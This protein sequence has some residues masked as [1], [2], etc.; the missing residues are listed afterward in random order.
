MKKISRKYFK[1]LSFVMVLVLSVGFFGK[2]SEA[3]AATEPYLSGTMI[4]DSYQMGETFSLS[5]KVKGDGDYIEKIHIHYYNE[6]NSNDCG[7]LGTVYPD[8]KSYSL[9]KLG[10]FTV[11][12]DCFKKVNATYVVKAWAKNEG[13]ASVLLDSVRV[14]ITE[15]SEPY[16]SG[17]MLSDTYT[18]GDT[19][20]LGGKVYGDGEYLEKIYVHYYNINN[21]GDNGVLGTS[22]PDA[23]SYSLSKF[24]SFTVGTDCFK[25]AN[26]KYLV[27]IY[28]KNE[29]GKSVLLDSRYVTVKKAAGSNSRYENYRQNAETVLGQI[30]TGTNA[31]INV[32]EKAHGK[33]WAWYFQNGGKS[34]HWCGAFA[35]YVLSLSGVDTGEYKYESGTYAWN[36]TKVSYSVNYYSA[37]GAYSSGGDVYDAVQTG[38]LVVMN[39]KGHIGVVYVVGDTKYV[40]HGNVGDGKDYVNSKVAV[41]ELKRGNGTNTV[42]GMGVNGYISME[43]FLTNNTWVDVTDSIPTGSYYIGDYKLGGVRP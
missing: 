14:K 7:V 2:V 12:E 21:T 34:T 19:F 15:A 24:G 42:G 33:V 4:E 5:G 31:Y 27:R 23:K 30:A 38:D 36:Q 16:L 10:K 43:S 29:G 41:H 18:I 20:T 17:T 25:K 35:H 26:A 11:G 32:G 28:A 13:G 3:K 40:V 1:F 9:S 39:N 6:K 22:Y 8:K 37:S